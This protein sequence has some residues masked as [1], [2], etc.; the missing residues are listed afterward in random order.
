MHRMADRTAIALV[1]K[2]VGQ[3]RKKRGKPIGS[4]SSHLFVVLQCDLVNGVAEGAWACK[5]LGELV[6]VLLRLWRLDNPRG[7][8]GVWGQCKTAWRDPW[9]VS[10]PSISF[11][12]LDKVT[13]Q[14]LR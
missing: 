11:K 3:R 12:S 2:G 7:R 13:I 10:E 5:L 14:I 9:W 1:K 6:C 8:H 4:H